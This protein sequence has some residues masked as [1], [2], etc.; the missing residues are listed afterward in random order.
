[1]SETTFAVPPAATSV[2]RTTMMHRL[3]REPLAVIGFSVIVLVVA[4]AVIGPVLVH[5][6]PTRADIN[7]VLLAPGVRGHVLGTDSAGRDVLARLLSG[8]RTSLSGAVV[9]SGVALLI[10]IPLGLIAGY[11]GGW[12]DNVAEWGAGVVMSMPAMVVLLATVSVFGP[13][14]Y[15]IMAVFGLLLVPAVFRLTR[16]GVHAVRNELY[17]DA[18]RVSGVGAGR[19]IR[20]HVLR[21]VRPPLLIQGAMI[22]GIAVVVQAG[23]DFLGVGNPA[24]PSWGQMLNDAFANIYRAPLLFIWPGVALGITVGALA[25]IGTALRDATQ[26]VATTKRAKRTVPAMVS[27]SQISG[28]L[29]E[30]RNLKVAYGATGQTVVVHDVSFRVKRGETLGLVGESGSGKSQTA[31]AV[32]GLLPEGGRVTAGTIDISGL[33]LVGGRDVRGKTVERMRGARIGYVPQEPM[34]N[35]DPAFTLGAQLTE[36]MRRHLGISRKEAKKR[37]LELLE[38]VG[39][40]DPERTFRSYPHEVSG[41]MAQRAL[42]AGAVSCDPE[43]L[44]ADE[45]TTALD[46]TVQAEVLDVIRQLRDERNL[47]VLLVT[48][49][50]G[51]V[52][53]ICDHVAVMQSGR[54]IEQGTTSDVFANPAQGYTR[55]LLGST[56]E[57]AEPRPHLTSGRRG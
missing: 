52:A 37:A 53:D 5:W 15:L 12:L 14:L 33:R 44:I 17:V 19:I 38:S 11:F 42:I 39:I 4:A 35:L 8:A 21:V 10:G 34:S 36:P 28:E 57:D 46:V 30:V 7:N 23:L 9:A 51:V 13:G 24:V 20:R 31:F 43:L 18:A 32:L 45:P 55:M 3:S 2:A 25:L 1:V 49:D 56:L 6:S 16:S 22:A 41:G 40:A 50:F 26:P 47:G 29:L 27:T 54:V 48:H